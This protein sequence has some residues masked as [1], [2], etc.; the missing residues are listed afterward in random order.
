M[1]IAMMLKADPHTTETIWNITQR[2]TDEIHKWKA[3]WVSALQEAITNTIERAHDQSD[4]PDF[5]YAWP[6]AN[7]A[8]GQRMTFQDL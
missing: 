4:W 3:E 5:T 7:K 6:N 1:L 2:I 8:I